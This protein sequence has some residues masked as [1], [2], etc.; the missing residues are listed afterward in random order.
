[1][2][3]ASQTDLAS[4]RSLQVLLEEFPLGRVWKSS[5]RT[6]PSE[7]FLKEHFTVFTWV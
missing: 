5:S 6:V 2:S 7:V 3:S 4:E 1:M